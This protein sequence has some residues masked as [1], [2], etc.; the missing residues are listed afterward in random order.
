M[1]SSK[2][3]QSTR[4]TVLSLAATVLLASC[5]GDSTDSSD[6]AESTII[7]API[8]EDAPLAA[9]PIVEQPVAADLPL[10][11]TQ[12][13]TPL[14]AD[15]NETTANQQGS[16][17]DADIT[18]DQQPSP[19]DTNLDDSQQSPSLADSPATPIVVTPESLP[20]EEPVVVEEQV[21]IEQPVVVEEPVANDTPFS[22]TMTMAFL[23]P[24]GQP[25][26]AN[27]P[28][29]DS[30]PWSRGFSLSQNS[31]VMLPDD[32]LADSFSNHYCYQPG[33]RLLQAV[34]SNGDPFWSF[35]LPG[36]N[37]IN[38]IDGIALTTT[39][40]LTIVANVT[41]EFGDPRHEMSSFSHTGEFRQ[42]QNILEF[43][44]TPWPAINIQGE[45][46]IVDKV[47]F[48]F[49]LGRAWDL[50]LQGNYYELQPGGN[51]A[52]PADWEQ[53]GTITALV[54][55]GTGEY[56]KLTLC[57]GDRFTVPSAWPGGAS[58]CDDVSQSGDLSRNSAQSRLRNN[59]GLLASSGLGSAA[60]L[61]AVA[62][63]SVESLGLTTDL[64]CVQNGFDAQC[65]TSL[66]P[67]VGD[68]RASTPITV[69]CAGEA[70]DEELFTF[71][72]AT[73]ELTQV[74]VRTSENTVELH[75]KFAFTNRCLIN[76]AAGTEALLGDVTVVSTMDLTTAA[77]IDRETIF[78]NLTA[79][80]GFTVWRFVDGSFRSNNSAGQST[81]Y[82]LQSNRVDSG[83]ICSRS[84]APHIGFN[85]NF[86][87]VDLDIS[88]FTNGDYS[89]DL[90]AGWTVTVG[91][92]EL[93][94]GI[95]DF[96]EVDLDFNASARVTEG[97][98]PFSGFAEIEDHLGTTIRMAPISDVNFPNLPLLEYELSQIDGNIESWNLPVRSFIDGSI[99][100]LREP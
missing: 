9:D 66:L 55:R 74:L 45:P 11:D 98:N 25:P 59:I 63:D 21:V 5:S 40:N 27:L 39:D 99:T 83:Q 24:L 54:N 53:A 81:S 86:T 93:L 10:T 32:C 4:L 52:T 44:G 8:S 23:Q 51:R 68:R 28:V 3:Y 90:S 46:L 49:S 18:V 50:R 30:T 41:S 97:E 80:R 88:R 12:E 58:V 82:S 33:S 26:Y 61:P 71:V 75:D 87:E 37:T 62:S 19:P 36:D 6:L 16:S 89:Y 76:D 7:P 48:S 92:P 85:G 84:C 95:P 31:G 91:R 73:A 34:L 42:T 69:D 65:A 14:P 100:S 78:D 17:T 96:I 2:T 57:E 77:I 64:P 22:S 72:T 35:N 47:D 29:V 94:S 20:I 1:M 70:F 38:R 67:A 56:M 43:E 15:I 79:I 13:S 60:E